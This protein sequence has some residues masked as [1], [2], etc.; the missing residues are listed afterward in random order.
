M[1]KSAECK[2]FNDCRSSLL[3]CIKQS[4]KDVSDKILEFLAPANQEYVR[5]DTHDVGDKARLIIDA[6][7]SQIENNPQVFHSFVSALKTAG[8]VTEFTVQKLDDAFIIQRQNQLEQ[9]ELYN[10]SQ[11]LTCRLSTIV[12]IIMG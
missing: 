4:P 3:I 2:A 7:A 5:N 6:V 8:D 10:Q 1:S 9:C 11:N 12:V